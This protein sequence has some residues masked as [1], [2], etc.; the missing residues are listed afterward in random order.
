MHTPASLSPALP[1]V[2]IVDDDYDGAFLVR[3]R[4]RR[5]EVRNPLLT[6]HSA[7][8]VVGFLKAAITAAPN[9]A[10]P[11]LVITDLQMP[12]FDGFELIT[13]IR[14]REHLAG[15][16]VV[17]ISV[18]EDAKGR[19]R[20]MK[21]GA[22]AHYVKCPRAEALANEVLRASPGPEPRPAGLA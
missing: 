8:E 22:D 16:R 10:K 17:A 21:L 12:G 1:P 15:V 6:F 13:W 18:D 4:L 9:T 2:L 14:A 20:A 5:A 3:D 19:A 7:K 11:C